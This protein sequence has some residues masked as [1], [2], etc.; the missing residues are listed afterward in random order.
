MFSKKGL[1]DKSQTRTWN[2]E[3]EDKRKTMNK[4]N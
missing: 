3:R 4:K 2:F 1:M